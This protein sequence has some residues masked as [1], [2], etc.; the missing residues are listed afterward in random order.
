MWVTF[1]HQLLSVIYGRAEH[2]GV[3]EHALGE[4]QNP[5]QPQLIIIEGRE[6]R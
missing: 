1:L 3:S 6:N 5:V 2:L 4:M